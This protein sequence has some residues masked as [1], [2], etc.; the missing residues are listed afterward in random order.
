[1]KD[2]SRANPGPKRSLKARK[3][4]RIFARNDHRV[5]QVQDLGGESP[6]E[7]AIVALMETGMVFIN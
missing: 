2:R 6:G 4:R 1:M 3:W 5:K 7:E